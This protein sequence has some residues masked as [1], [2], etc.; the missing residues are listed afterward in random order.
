MT[1]RSLLIA[2]VVAIAGVCG[3][4]HASMAQVS[5]KF[6]F[7]GI[8]NCHNPNLT[9]YPIRGEGTGKLSTDRSAELKM[10]SNV[11]GYSDYRV[12]LGDKP[13]EVENGTAQLR[14]SSTRSL[15]ATREYP[16]N[17]IIVDLKVSGSKCSISISQRLKPGKRE[18]T[19]QTPFGIAYCSRPTFTKTSCEPI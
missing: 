17:Y 12:K 18:Y 9:N 15:R 10:L 19:F 11:E 16:N 3:L 14:V 6:T 1:P 4:P 5:A 2:G 7:E 13:A 8:A